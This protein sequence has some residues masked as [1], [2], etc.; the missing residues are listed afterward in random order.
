MNAPVKFVG[1]ATGPE[2]Y[3]AELGCRVKTF[4]EEPG[5]RAPALTY[6]VPLEMRGDFRPGDLANYDPLKN[7]RTDALGKVLC[8]AKTVAGER[9][10]KRAQNR[11]PR[12]VVHGGRLHPLDK[13]I[14]DDETDEGGNQTESLSRYRQFQA[15]QITVDDLDDEELA[16]CG[17]R[18]SNGAIYK[19]RNV[20]REMAQAFVR[21]I[22]ERAQREL[23]GQAVEAARTMAEIMM[24]K[25]VEPDVRLKA[26]NIILERN[27]GKAPQV[28]QIT[29]QA[30]WEEIFDGI[31][32]GSRESARKAITSERVDSDSTIVGNSDSTIV[33]NSDSSLPTINGDADSTI[34]AEIIEEDE[35]TRPTS[36]EEHNTTIDQDA[37]S[38]GLLDDSAGNDCNTT[39]VINNDSNRSSEL[40]EPCGRAQPIDYGSDSAPLAST[41]SDVDPASGVT[42]AE[43]AQTGVD[44]R[45][46][47]HNPAILAQTVEIKPFKFDLTN[48]SVDIKKERAKRY[49][50]RALGIDITGPATPLMREILERNKTSELIRHTDPEQIKVPKSVKS[51]DKKRKTYTLNDFKTD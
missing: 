38:D 42:V 10:S 41:P 16:A 9:C 17:F 43:D 32:G 34:T 35:S 8:Y 26:A 7:Y 46:F 14:K 30:P 40:P 33:G 20:P 28:I 21:A 36:L 27:L 47:E 4:T 15:G 3:V 45:L 11:Y 5:G 39:E 25:T 48:K 22:Y 18:A 2:I 6:H 19:P 44:A 24:N 12:C 13:F 49:V 37:Q 29:N 50:S 51:A 31:T 23:R 1:E